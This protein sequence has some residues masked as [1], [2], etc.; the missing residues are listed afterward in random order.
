MSLIVICAPT[1]MC[2]IKGKIFYAKLNLILHQC[3]EGAHSLIVLGI[4][5]VI[6]GTKRAGFE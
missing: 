4:F 1:E 5:N 3:S 6:A 2:E